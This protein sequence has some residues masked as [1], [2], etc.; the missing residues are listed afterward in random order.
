MQ[1]EYQTSTRYDESTESST[2]GSD[3]ATEVKQKVEETAST[4]VTQAQQVASQVASTQV[5]SQKERAASTLD[6]VAK[7]LYETGAGI[8]EQQP[9][10]AGIADEAASRVVDASAYLREHDLRDL[11]KETES[12]ARREPLI[13][14]GAAFALG[15]VA[16]RFIKA[17]APDQSRSSTNTGNRELTGS[18]TGGRGGTDYASSSDYGDAG[19]YKAY[20]TGNGNE[21][22]RSEYSSY[23]S[24]DSDQR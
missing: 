3:A 23:G 1:T 21:S 6:A 9:Q 11:V 20:A 15:F 12:F 17:S 22:D 18:Y 8:R 14:L 5:S 4:L 13:F 19:T 2:T 7:T 10:I 16:A 24:S